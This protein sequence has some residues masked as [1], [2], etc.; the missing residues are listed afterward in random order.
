MISDSENPDSAQVKVVKEGN[1]GSKYYAPIVSNYE[2]T[3]TGLNIGS[4]YIVL[5]AVDN[6]GNAAIDAVSVLEESESTTTTA[7]HNDFSLNVDNEAPTLTST[8]SGAHY[9]NTVK[10]IAVEGSFDDNASKVKSVSLTV[11]GTTIAS[12]LDSDNKKW[13]ITIPLKVLSKFEDGKVY[14]VNASVTDNAG[15]TET[16]HTQSL[17]G[18]RRTF[19]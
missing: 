7:T 16:G 3:I 11:N 13:S 9:T 1:V 5:V 12:N 6:V 8:R 15:N 2:S 4:N 14:N 18:M 10:P 19:C 17:A